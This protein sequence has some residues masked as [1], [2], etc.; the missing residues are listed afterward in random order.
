MKLQTKI[1]WLLFYGAQCS[2][3]LLRSFQPVSNMS[4]ITD[5]IHINKDEVQMMIS[6]VGISAV[7]SFQCLD[8]VTLLVGQQKWQPVC[9]KPPSVISKNSLLGDPRDPSCRNSLTLEKKAN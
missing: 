6:L 5:I 4:Y 8:T 3:T 9:K 7:S 1:S 2:N